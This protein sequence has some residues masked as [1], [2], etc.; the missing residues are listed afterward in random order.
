MSLI[1]QINRLIKEEIE[2]DPERIGYAG[3]SD[4]EITALLNEPQ[5]KQVIS[6]EVL[7]SPMSRILKGISGAPN[8]ISSE[9]V[10]DAKRRGA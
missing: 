4:E 10:S 7:P 2:N 9:E 5:R 3:K 8:S 6:E 1:D